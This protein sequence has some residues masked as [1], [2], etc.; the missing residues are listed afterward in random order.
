MSVFE[1]EAGLETQDGSARIRIDVSE[2]RGFDARPMIAEI[3]TAKLLLP[4]IAI[5]FWKINDGSTG[6]ADGNDN[7]LIENAETV[8]IRLEVK[9]KGAGPAYGLVLTPLVAGAVIPLSSDVL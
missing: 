4:E 8:E 2:G 3:P 1:L 9:N 5:D 7:R 6:M